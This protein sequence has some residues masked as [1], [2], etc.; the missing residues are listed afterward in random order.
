[1]RHRKSF[2]RLGRPESH[3]RA[4]LMN[5][6]KSLI[7]HKRIV[8]T[9]EKAKEL[10]KFVEPVLTKLKTDTT[11]SRRV[12]FSLFQDKDVVKELFNE[13]AGKIAQRAGGYTRII[14]LGNRIG[15]NAQVCL[16]ELVDYN[17]LYK[18]RD[19]P[20]KATRRSKG[21]RRVT[22][23]ISEM[24]LSDQSESPV[25]GGVDGGGS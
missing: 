4:L 16:M 3:R 17:D 10:R 11:H 15:D 8:T 19:K 24:T 7:Q 25:A 21:K 20:V 6:S 13:I 5:L 23:G 18:K 14:K 9:V 1:M 22:A 12:V 2:N